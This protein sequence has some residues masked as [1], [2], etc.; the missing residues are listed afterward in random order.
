[1]NYYMA[2]PEDWK[3]S[4]I[5]K[6]ALITVATTVA[7]KVVRKVVGKVK[8]GVNSLKKVDLDKMVRD[9]K[10]Q[11]GELAEKVKKGAQHAGDELKSGAA[12]AGKKGVT[13]VVREQ[14]INPTREKVQ[15]TL[16][17]LVM[18]KYAAAAELQIPGVD[19]FIG[20]YLSTEKRGKRGRTKKQPPV[21]QETADSVRNFVTALRDD[22][23]A[24]PLELGYDKD[25]PFIR[26]GVLNI[27]AGYATLDA[28]YIL[29]RLEAATTIDYF[30]LNDKDPSLREQEFAVIRR[31]AGGIR[32]LAAQ[33]DT[34]ENLEGEGQ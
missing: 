10:G 17:S 24:L 5:V 23:D 2:S 1:M 30:V 12:Y 4:P 32:E 26:K 19:A 33:Y 13:G 8:E 16:C 3:D 34:K 31:Y 6:I 22:Y 7:S 29:K 20:E 27:F 28:D 14:F 21:L 15:G 25:D 9:P 18:A 11:A